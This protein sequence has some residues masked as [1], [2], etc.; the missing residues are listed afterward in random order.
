MTLFKSLL[1]EKYCHYCGKV[2][3]IICFICLKSILQ[4][5][6]IREINNKKVLYFLKNDP[7]IIELKIFIPLV[8]YLVLLFM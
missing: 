4:N 7:K 6:S 2:D 3:E 1:F 5:Y 8:Q